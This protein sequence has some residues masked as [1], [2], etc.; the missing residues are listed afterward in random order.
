MCLFRAGAYVMGER[1]AAARARLL[2]IQRAAALV[3]LKGVTQSPGA[4]A[5]GMYVNVARGC[6]IQCCMQASPFRRYYFTQY[7][8]T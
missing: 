3:R 6:M 7:Y 1:I 8:N 4:T 2:E 5:A